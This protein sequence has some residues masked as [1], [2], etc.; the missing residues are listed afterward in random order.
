MKD[1]P[2]CVREWFLRS[3]AWAKRLSHWSQACGRIC[4]WTDCLCVFKVFDWLNDLSHWSQANGLSPVCVNICR[5][6]LVNATKHLPH[7]SQ[8]CERICWCTAFLWKRK[9]DDRE[10]VVLHWSHE[11]GC[12]PIKCNQML[13]YF[14][15]LLQ[16]S[17]QILLQHLTVK[18]TGMYDKMVFEIASCSEAF[19]TLW[20]SMWTN[21]IMNC[22]FM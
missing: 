20:T 13:R 21:L 4:S 19:I 2:V 9:D 1:S 17:D 5:S 18:L 8:T 11:Y 14:K 16:K 7:C 15:C 22:L 10:N 3:L 6:K 12:S